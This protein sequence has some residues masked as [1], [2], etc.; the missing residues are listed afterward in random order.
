MSAWESMMKRVLSALA[1]VGL[2]TAV[3]VWFRSVDVWDVLA[4]PSAGQM[5]LWTLFRV[6]FMLCLGIACLTAGRLVLFWH[7]RL[8][9]EL[10]LLEQL[11]FCFF[12]GASVLRMAMFGVGLLGGYSPQLAFFGMVPLVLLF[13][14]IYDLG[15]MCSKILERLRLNV[16]QSILCLGLCGIAAALLGIVYFGSCQYSFDGDYLTHYGPYYE[17]VIQSGG[18]APNDVWYQYFYS[19]GAG[20]FYLSMLITDQ[21]GPLLVSFLHFFAATLL[22]Y[23]VVRRASG[24]ALWAL[25]AAVFMLGMMAWPI[26][27]FFVKHHCEI[28]SITLSITAAVVGLVASKR[29]RS[30]C[31]Y[32][33]CI[34]QA[35]LMIYSLQ[36]GVFTLMFIGVYAVLALVKRDY[37]QFKCH[38]FVLALA[39]CISI[40]VM[41]HNYSATGLYEITPFRVFLKYWNQ[42]TFSRWVS[43]YLMF[44]LSEGSSPELGTIGI[45]GLLQDV[46]MYARLF[47]LEKFFFE[48]RFWNLSFI[49]CFLGL[50]GCYTEWLKNDSGESV[51]GFLV[52][53]RNEALQ[54]HFS[55]RAD[56]TFVVPFTRHEVVAQGFSAEEMVTLRASMLRFVLLPSFGMCLLVFVVYVLVR[57]P[58]SILRM[59]EFVS[60]YVTLFIFSVLIIW[61]SLVPR[62]LLYR[63]VGIAFPI[64]FAFV[65]FSWTIANSHNERVTKPLKFAMG[66]LKPIEL[67]PVDPALSAR[68]HEI[69]EIAGSESPIVS[70]NLNV[71]YGPLFLRYPGI[72][73]EVSYG[74]GNRWHEVVFGEPEAAKQACQELG[75]N[76]FLVDLD[77]PFFGA[78]PY[79]PLFAARSLETNFKIVWQFNH[80]YLLTWDT[81]QK[82]MSDSFLLEWE[83]AMYK[84]MPSVFKADADYGQMLYDQVRYLYELN[85]HA[86]HGVIRPKKLKRVEGWQ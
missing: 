4:E 74:F 6:S 71:D 1:L 85:D 21:T 82:Q 26:E 2:F 32:F 41:L 53:L 50:W 49:L 16:L 28:S 30:L 10:G 37:G 58:V 72:M 55:P 39:G 43:P 29:Y 12:T 63:L 44:Y 19:K 5:P 69:R 76:Y 15:E 48:M 47:R 57:Q 25:S 35:S 23:A 66:M 36:A 52:R 60:L 77:S 42:E 70:L 27:G 81:E 54:H 78:L 33:V 86:T 14:F 68:Y 7:R 62:T 40:L 11:L 45:S 67:S 64:A 65:A 46:I 51:F 13:P 75:I 73:T 59:S 61:H 80:R 24:S 22:M 9:D 38:F 84:K 83:L 34:S 18:L 31:F 8:L 56:A 17:A 20:L 3:F 79:S